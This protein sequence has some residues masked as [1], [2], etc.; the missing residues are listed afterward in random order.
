MRLF[1]LYEGKEMKMYKRIS[2]KK[3]IKTFEKCNFN[4]AETARKLNVCHT[5]TRERLAKLGVQA[6]NGGPTPKYNKDM[7]IK[8][9]QLCKGNYSEM[10]RRFGTTHAGVYQLMKKYE[11]YKAYPAAG[12]S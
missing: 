6:G 5:N 7:L 10:G 9:Y 8:M 1:Q 4:A 3:L 12:K 11:L 2:D